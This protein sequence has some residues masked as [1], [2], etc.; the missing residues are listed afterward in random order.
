MIK[1]TIVALI[2][3][4][5]FSLVSCGDKQEPKEDTSGQLIMEKI[6]GLKGVIS[7]EAVENNQS[8]WLPEKYAVMV[9]Q[10]IDWNDPEAGTFAQLVEVGIHPGAEVNVLET[11][12]YPFLDGDLAGDNQPEVCVILEA[13]HI[14]VEHRFS[15]ISFPEGMTNYSKDG[16]EYLTTENESGDYHHVYEMFS[17]IFNGQWV[18]YGRSR[19]GRACV[20]YARHYPGDMKGYVPYVGVNCNGEHDPRVMDYVNTVIGDNAFG[21]E[22]AAR[23]R[24]LMDDFMVECIRN[25]EQLQNI[26]WDA[27]ASMGRS[28]PEWTTRERLLDLTLLEFQVEFWQDDGDFGDIENVLSLPDDDTEKRAAK[29]DAIYALFPRYGGDPSFYS[30]DYFGFSYYVGA[31]V[32]EGNYEIDFSHLREVLKQAGLDDQLAIKPEDQKDLLRN[33]VLDDDQKD[34]FV[35]IPGHYEALDDFAK[36]TDQEIVFI[37]GDLDPWS[38]VYVDGGDNPN[39]K[40]YI[41]IGKA[42]H[43]QIADFDQD[44]QKEIIETIRSWVQ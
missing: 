25:R 21:K 44:T 26:L 20:D 23:R 8:E 31:L 34:H 10:Q 29:N 3:L 36:T 9:E 1:L 43:T 12:G 11:Y 24:K 28:F 39:F 7:V 27:M 42:H 2:S 41:L 30:H 18:A 22:E 14:K 16:W 5:M 4:L 17:Q 38:A 15:G 19:G 40:S 35:F 6:A 13:N 33:F 32:E 37:G